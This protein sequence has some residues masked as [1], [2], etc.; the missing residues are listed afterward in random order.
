MVIINVI[1]INFNDVENSIKLKFSNPCKLELTVFIKV[2][3][4]NLKEL[5]NVIPVKLSNDVNINK[6]KINI[7]IVKKYLFIS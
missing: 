2:K 3:I 5:I 6:D 1:K 4:A 7:I